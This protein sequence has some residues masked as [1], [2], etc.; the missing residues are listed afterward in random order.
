MR[1]L[2]NPLRLDLKRQTAK[3]INKLPLES[4]YIPLLTQQTDISDLLS[5]LS[6]L[7]A[8][9]TLTT[10]IADLY[11]PILFDLCARW[12][13]DEENNVD[14]LVALCLLVEVHEHLFP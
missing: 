10:S 7:L 9:P 11:R 1:S 5:L 4:V 8:V 6:R 12:L 14:Q 3:L 2:A 13:E